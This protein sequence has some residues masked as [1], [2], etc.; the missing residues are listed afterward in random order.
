[1]TLAN[2]NTAFLVPAQSRVPAVSVQEAKYEQLVSSE[3]VNYMQQCSLRQ[4]KRCVFL[5][6]NCGVGKSNHNGSLIGIYNP[7]KSKVGSITNLMSQ[8]LIRLP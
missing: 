6:G 4:Y 5:R 1:M 8:T 3:P 7:T 2:V